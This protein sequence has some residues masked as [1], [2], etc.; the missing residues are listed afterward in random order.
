VCFGIKGLQET[1]G[2]VDFWPCLPWCV[3][4]CVCVCACVC[5]C[6]CVRGE[7]GGGARVCAREGTGILHEEQQMSS[8][9]GV[10]YNAPQPALTL[11][12][13]IYVLVCRLSTSP[14]QSSK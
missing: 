12:I 7:G 3:C 9:F 14:S 2:R 6:V 11:K 1:S 8:E 13:C 10:G 4:V 5:V